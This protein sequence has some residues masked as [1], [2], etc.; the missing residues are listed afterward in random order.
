MNFIHLLKLLS[1]EIEE[2]ENDF[3][4]SRSQRERL[5]TILRDWAK[6]KFDFDK[7]VRL[8]EVLTEG[9]VHPKDV[10]LWVSDIEDVIE[11]HYQGLAK[12]WPNQESY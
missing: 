3:L 6:G 11:G 12:V 9:Q 7:A 1:N 10:Y 8:C 2:I 4:L 5:F